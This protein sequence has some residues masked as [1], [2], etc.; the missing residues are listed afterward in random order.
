MRRMLFSYNYKTKMVTNHKGLNITRSGV[1][2]S[3][4]HPF[5]GATPDGLVECA[6]CG[7]G[8]VELSVH[9]VL[10]RTFLEH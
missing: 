7:K 9:C 4:E 6:C 5:L 8:V 3:L 1:Y 2:V 10:G